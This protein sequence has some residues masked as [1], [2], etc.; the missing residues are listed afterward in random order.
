MGNGDAEPRSEASPPVAGR[1]SSAAS[2]KL[3]LSRRTTVEAQ[4]LVMRGGSFGSFVNDISYGQSQLILHG[5]SQFSVWYRAIGPNRAHVAVGRRSL[6]QAAWQ[7]TALTDWTLASDNT[8]ENVTMGIAPLDGT[9]HFAFG[10]HAETLNRRSSTQ[11]FATSSLKL[12]PGQ[13]SS[14]RSDFGSVRPVKAVTYPQFATTPGG[15]TQMF[16]RVGVSGAGDY[17]VATYEPATGKWGTPLR[18]IG[19]AG[20]YEFRDSQGFVVRST[21]RNAYPNGFHYGPNGRLHVT[22]IWRERATLPR[23]KRLLANHDLYYAFSD[24]QGKTWKTNDGASAALPIT[25]ATPKARVWPLPPTYGTVNQQAQA[26]D[27][28]GQ[29][30]V[31]M[32]H[33]NTPGDPYSFGNDAYHHYHRTPEGKWHHAVLK[34]PGGGRPRLVFDA[35][36][37]AYLLFQRGGRLTVLIAVAKTEWTDWRVAFEA[38]GVCSDVDADAGLLMRTNKQLVLQAQ[39]CSSTGNGSALEVYDLT[40]TR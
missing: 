37:T 6:G 7:T 22:W 27:S 28:R 9:V 5:N 17:E 35:D 8:H 32:G 26:V 33:R 3:V 21:S 20:A 31:V 40:I 38:P 25:V 24:D 29:P 16:Y 19:R 23:G 1:P 15:R 18:F 2:V 30:H 36:D 10:M 13:F 12:F 14:V 11:G 4:A 34:A 39:A